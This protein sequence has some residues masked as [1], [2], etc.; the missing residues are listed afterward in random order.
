MNP[1]LTA[2]AARLAELHAEEQALRAEV[3]DLARSIPCTL[4]TSS[5]VAVLGESVEVNVSPVGGR[6]HW[7]TEGDTGLLKGD[8]N[9]LEQG[10][11]AALLAVDRF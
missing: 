7:S 8:E 4:G 2:I 9:T 6:F 3:L 10:I 5:Y 1:R 11:I